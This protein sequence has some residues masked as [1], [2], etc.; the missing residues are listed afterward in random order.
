MVERAYL[1]VAN[2]FRK[3][4]SFSLAPCTNL[5]LNVIFFLLLRSKVLFIKKAAKSPRTKVRQNAAA[6]LTTFLSLFLSFILSSAA[7]LP[8][9]SA[10]TF[11]LRRTRKHETIVSQRKQRD[12]RRVGVKTASLLVKRPFLVQ[13]HGYKMCPVVAPRPNVS[14]VALSLFP[15]LSI[16]LASHGSC[17]ERQQKIF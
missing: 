8:H 12:A 15:F 16:S 1:N 7:V 4:S 13:I 10:V 11:L 17:F 5:L 6:K 14:N 9:L 2:S 3:A